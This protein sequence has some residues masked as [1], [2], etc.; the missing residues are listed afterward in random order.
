MNGA[1]AGN[2]QVRD[3]PRPYGEIVA[4]T[5]AFSVNEYLCRRRLAQQGVS[6]VKAVDPAAP[7]PTLAE[8]A[9]LRL[10]FEF[11]LDILLALAVGGQAAQEATAE[12]CGIC[13]CSQSDPCFDGMGEACAW[14]TEPR[15]CTMCIGKEDPLLQSTALEDDRSGSP[16]STT[17]R[18][19]RA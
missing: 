7:E 17:L 12:C 16:Q 18:G 3:L 10:L 4:Q 2:P 5:T 11:D 15:L 19:D 13:A 14:A 8:L 6:G 1:A 9:D